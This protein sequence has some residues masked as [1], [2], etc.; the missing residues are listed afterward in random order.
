MNVLLDIGYFVP[1]VL[2]NPLS[3]KKKQKNKKEQKK[4]PVLLLARQ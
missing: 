2:H 4:E 1:Y 3:K